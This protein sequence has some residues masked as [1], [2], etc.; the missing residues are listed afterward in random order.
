MALFRKPVRKILL[1]FASL[2]GL[3]A[4]LF[5]R[6]IGTENNLSVFGKRA[7]NLFYEVSVIQ[8]A[9]AQY[10]SGGSCGEGECACGGCE[11]GGCGGCE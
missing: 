7:K 9:E 10:C 4:L 3:L 2:A 8:S 1:S 11:G 5:F 6:I